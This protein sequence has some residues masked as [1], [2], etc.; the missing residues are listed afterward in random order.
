[1]GEGAR[2]HN[3]F[4]GITWN[5]SHEYETVSHSGIF[6]RSYTTLVKSLAMLVVWDQLTCISW[7]K[8]PKV[9]VLHKG[10]YIL[11]RGDWGFL[12]VLD[13][14]LLKFWPFPRRP[15]KAGPAWP[16]TKDHL[17]TCD[18]PHLPLTHSLLCQ[19]RTRMSNFPVPAKT[20]LT[21]WRR[22]KP[23]PPPPLPVFAP[24]FVLDQ[25]CVN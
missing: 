11:R 4:E 18:P 6:P 22:E 14:S 2:I 13:M 15:A 24:S 1:M 23:Q 16:F 3:H 21:K 20:G 5:F 12:G 10:R 19:P 25:Y 17:K 8:V 7:I 9:N